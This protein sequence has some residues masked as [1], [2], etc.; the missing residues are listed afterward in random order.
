MQRRQPNT[1]LLAWADVGARGCYLARFCHRRVR[2]LIAPTASADGLIL[3]RLTGRNWDFNLRVK[4]LRRRLHQLFDARQPTTDAACARLDAAGIRCWI[5]PRDV[6][7]G[8]EWSAAIIDAINQCRVMILIFSENA[9]RSPQIYREV[10]R[11]VN[12]SV[13]V[14]P[15]RIENITPDRSLEYFIGTVHW[16]DALTPPL[17]AHLRCL[18]VAV[19]AL[20]EIEA[21]PADA[22]LDRN[23]PALAAPTPRWRRLALGAIGLAIL[24]VTAIGFGTSRRP[25]KRRRR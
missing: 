20:L 14:L 18:V 10:E 5:A 23:A 13:P 24:A 7:P 22:L 11:A 25:E 4:A 3:A 16:L 17:E 2:A 8:K 1:S 19:T 12:K 6:T 21:T 15:L 9:N